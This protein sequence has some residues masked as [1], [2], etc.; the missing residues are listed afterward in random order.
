M[1]D[2][3]TA[4]LIQEIYPKEG[5]EVEV[6]SDGGTTWESV[7]E[8]TADDG[9]DIDKWFLGDDDS[10]VYNIPTS[11]LTDNFKI[12][13][14]GTSSAVSETI[15]IDNIKITSSS[16]APPDTVSP[17][18]ILL[19]PIDMTIQVNSEYIDP[20][21]SAGDDIDGNITSEVVVLGSVDVT[22]LGT[23]TIT[24]NV[25]DSSN[26][27]AIQ[28]VRTIHVVD[29]I[30]PVIIAPDDMTFEA[31][32]ILTTLTS[33]DYGI[34]SVTDNFDSNP[35]IT[36]NAP[37]SF[38][39]GDTIIIWTATDDSNNSST[40]T[41]IITIQDTTRPILSQPDDITSN[42]VLVTFDVPTATDSVDDD[43][44]V[45]CDY[46]S[47]SEFVIGTTT[48]TCT[49]TDDSG[50]SATVSF[51]ITVEEP[52]DPVDPVPLTIMAPVDIT[53][54]AAGILTT[55]TSAD[56]G[57]ATAA[58]D[59]DST[60][61]ITNDAPATFPLG[62]TIITWTGTDNS[63]NS[64]TDTQ[65][66]TI[67]DTTRPILSQPDDITSDSVLVTFDLPTATDVVDDD[68][69]VTCDYTSGSEF[70]IGTTTVT[71]TGTDDSDNYDTVSFDITVQEP[72][73]PVDPVDPTPL[74]VQA[75]VISD[76]VIL[77]WADV[78]DSYQITRGTAPFDLDVTVSDATHYFDYSVN[79]GDS[80]VYSVMA[81]D[82]NNIL[83]HH[84]IVNAIVTDNTGYSGIPVDIVPFVL[85]LTIEAPTDITTEASGILTVLDI[86]TATSDYPV[87]S[88]ASVS[89]PLGD[90]IITWTASN[91]T[92]SV[93][94][95]QTITI[96]DT[97]PS[98][99]LTV[100][101][102]VTTSNVVSFDLPIGI[103]IVDGIITSTCD[104]ASGSEFMIGTTTVTCTTI[105]SSANSASV[106]FDVIV[107][108]INDGVI[109]YT[110]DNSLD[111]W[112]F[113]VYDAPILV[114]FCGDVSSPYTLT[115]ST[116]HNGSAHISSTPLCWFGDAVG[117]K[118]FTIPSGYNTLNVD[119]DFRS[120]A[121]PGY[122]NISYFL[123]LNSDDHVLGFDVLYEPVDHLPLSDTDWLHTTLSMPFVSSSDCPCKIMMF[124]S[125]NSVV[126]TNQQLYFDN[127]NI[128]ATNTASQHSNV[129][130]VQNSLTLNDM[131]GFP[132]NSTLVHNVN[133]Y[134]DAIKLDW[135][136][137]D[138]DYKVVIAN[139]DTPREKFVDIATGDSYTFVNLEP[140]IV[141]QIRVGIRG[142]DS[143]Q[144]MLEFTTLPDGVLSYHS[145]IELR[146]VYNGN[147][148]DLSWLDS[149]DVGENRYR[150]E[151]S[152]NGEDY[153]LT[154]FI[155]KV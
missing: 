52:V 12:K 60:P 56:Y 105:D 97:I 59:T 51:D 119:F 135:V 79:A 92:H 58:D 77:L 111:S 4:P 93:N 143:T 154:D 18:I 61:T 104:Y 64:S 65:I 16:V 102:I 27:S 118:I 103:D 144:R 70:V 43:V 96:Q 14:I 137:F 15:Y 6:S 141:Y 78:G 28:K 72:V 150:I 22:M 30:P 107:L 145:G 47:G 153:I 50:N 71:C 86:G 113:D 148:V 31:I 5:L 124:L 38:P 21:Y 13:I 35:V 8:W 138:T 39:L 34:A 131:V 37:L 129:N 73:D 40:D 62:D 20:G 142:D 90:T 55:L 10:D 140:D 98:A 32:G 85:P 66:I 42:S 122:Y 17:I 120:L 121:D 139:S 54:E 146:A 68:V 95:T 74:R 67:Q 155:A 123:V 88:N 69:M 49:G 83:T 24:Y 9:H 91:S 84:E 106:S 2:G 94:A 87:S 33:A 151:Q 41:Q 80:V 76:F 110:F 45:T 127:V 48:V 7:Y 136:A 132:A 133:V 116:E 100:S 114:R 36:N 3:L 112:D 130:L 125:D 115:H 1:T 109:S 147:T 23:Y 46:T 117:S 53:F 25:S 126:P 101:D 82:S 108:E 128:N 11:K 26:N 19:P 63:N 134:S 75:S 89:F 57:V 81:Y 149:N 152:I 29:T 99:L 44:V